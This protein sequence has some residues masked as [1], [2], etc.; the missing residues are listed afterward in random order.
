MSTDGNNWIH[1]DQAFGFAVQPVFVDAEAGLLH[2]NGVRPGAGMIEVIQEIVYETELLPVAPNPFNP[3]TE[4]RF[5]LDEGKKIEISVFDI[6]GH[7]VADLVDEVYSSGLHSITW[8][9]RDQSGQRV[10]SGVYF[11]RLKV[12]GTSFIRRM[13][14]VK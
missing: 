12:G 5:S 7:K 8:Q 4:I 11:A 3:V 14:L 9:S 10:A 6:R 2:M 13:M 1:I